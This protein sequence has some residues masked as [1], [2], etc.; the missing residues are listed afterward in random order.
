MSQN[1]TEGLQFRNPVLKPFIILAGDWKT[2]GHHR[3]MP[4][5]TLHGIT[6]F[7]WLEGSAFLIMH[8]Q[9]DEPEVPDSVS[10]IGSDDATGRL[11]MLYID[12]RGVSRKFEVRFTGNVLEMW[13]DFP[14]FA[15]RCKCVLKD[16][17]ESMEGIWE[18]CEDGVN[19]VRDMELRYTKVEGR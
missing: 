2:V 7:S 13:R 8:T 19:W 11:F 15:Q 16:G 5:T 10:V 17:G 18:L 6:S 1:S 4:G 9:M 3:L 14:G 12:V